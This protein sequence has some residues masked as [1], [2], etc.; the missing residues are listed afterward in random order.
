MHGLQNLDADQ[1]LQNQ[2]E[3]IELQWSVVRQPCQDLRVLQKRVQKAKR[4]LGPWFS[5]VMLIVGRVR[6]FDMAV[7][8]RSDNSLVTSYCLILLSI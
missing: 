7:R 3:L 6:S 5:Q 2:Q 8:A 4:H 1:Y